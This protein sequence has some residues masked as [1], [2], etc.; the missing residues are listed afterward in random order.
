MGEK[1]TAIVGSLL[2][3]ELAIEVEENDVEGGEVVDAVVMVA[4]FARAETLC[5]SFYARQCISATVC[6]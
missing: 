3:A 2:K 1:V 5:F 6:I 4:T